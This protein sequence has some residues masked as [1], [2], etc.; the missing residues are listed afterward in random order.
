M[1]PLYVLFMLFI[2]S[3]A[4]IREPSVYPSVQIRGAQGSFD[5]NLIELPDQNMNTARKVIYD[6]HFS[7]ESD[8]PDSVIENIKKLTN[9]FDGYIVNH[10][11]NS[12]RIRVPAGSSEGIVKHIEQLAQVVDKNISGQDVTEQYSDLEIKLDN[13]EKARK[14]YLELLARAENVT[15]ALSVEK[16]LERLQR[17]YDLLKG[18][19]N[20][21]SHLVQYVT[22][23]V[24]VVKGVSPGPLGYIF[25]GLY[26]AVKWLFVW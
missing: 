15:A 9:A 26:E 23:D 5:G 1:K 4:T 21:L 20:R 3:C 19:Q 18:R 8:Q 11:K 17:E 16:E 12:I 6:V 7:L 14:R 10:G 24:Y 25:V 13:I 2:L 22:I